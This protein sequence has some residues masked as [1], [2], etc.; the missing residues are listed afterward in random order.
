MQV[1]PQ[2]GHVYVERVE[3][4]KSAIALV[5]DQHEE[6]SG[7]KVVAVAEFR[8]VASGCCPGCCLSY[9]EGMDRAPMDTKVGQYVLFKPRSGDVFRI[10]SRTFFNVSED[11]LL[12]SVDTL[13][14]FQQLTPVAV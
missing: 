13:E 14:E 11:N 8:P 10:A 12:L 6:A 3:P 2:P 7:G 4:P 1:T 9:V 5:T